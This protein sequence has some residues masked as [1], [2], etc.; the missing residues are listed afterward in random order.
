MHSFTCMCS[1]TNSFRRA[2]KRYVL[3]HYTA[4]KILPVPLCTEHIHITYL[5]SHMLSIQPSSVHKGK[6]WLCTAKQ[7][8]HCL[9]VY[10]HCTLIDPVRFAMQQ[11]IYNLQYN[12]KYSCFMLFLRYTTKLVVLCNAMKQPIL[13]VIL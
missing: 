10:P 2:L 6:S 7:Q 3:L 11:H 8:V 1:I 9:Y 12:A 5:I 13:P 4:I